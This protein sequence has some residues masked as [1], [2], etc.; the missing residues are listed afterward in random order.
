MLLAG[1]ELIEEA[2]PDAFFNAPKMERTK[3]FLRDLV[4][5]SAGP[6]ELPKLN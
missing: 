2:P 3:K 6:P 4:I 1:G 5:E